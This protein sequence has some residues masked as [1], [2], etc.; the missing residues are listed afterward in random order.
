MRCVRSSEEVVELG[1]ELVGMNDS[2]WLVGGDRDEFQE[3][4]GEVGADHEQPFLAVVLVLDIPEGVLPSVN[5]RSVVDAV[6]SSRR[7]NLHTCKPYLYTESVVKVVL[8]RGL[9]PERVRSRPET[10]GGHGYRSAGS[11]TSNR[12]VRHFGERSTA[13]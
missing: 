1:A 11:S 3:V 9:H 13:R 8:T 7:A 12:A 4:A 10:S 5:D 2:G 6:L